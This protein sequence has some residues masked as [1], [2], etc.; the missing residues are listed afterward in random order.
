MLSFYYRICRIYFGTKTEEIICHD[1]PLDL[2]TDSTMSYSSE[3]K[4]NLLE[5]IISVHCILLAQ[6]AKEHY[7]ELRNPDTY[8]M[9][10]YPEISIR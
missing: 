1:I 10:E 8:W 5:M 4:A 9:G 6:Y 3:D 7:S 2:N